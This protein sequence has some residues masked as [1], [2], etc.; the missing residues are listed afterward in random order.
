MLVR[1]GSSCQGFLQ[2]TPGLGDQFGY[3]KGFNQKGDIAF[4]QESASLTL[5]HC[6]RESEEEMPVHVRAIRL[7]PCVRL[8]R[9]PFAWHLAV[10][11]DGIKLFG[12]QSSLHVLTGSS[13]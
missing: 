7:E 2:Q 10:H 4:L 11:D 12:E 9:V 3:F 13:G 5:F 8:P 1:A 6:A